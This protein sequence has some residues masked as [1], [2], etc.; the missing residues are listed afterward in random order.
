MK[1]LIFLFSFMILFGCKDEKVSDEVNALI[2]QEQEIQ[3]LSSMIVNQQKI[4]SQ[5]RAGDSLLVIIPNLQIQQ[6]TV[7]LEAGL[8]DIAFQLDTTT[9]E[10]AKYNLYLRAS[11]LRGQIELLKELYENY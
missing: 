4:I 9:S 1:Q 6:T 3:R 8:K 11:R 2:S 10:Q 7:A 5:Y